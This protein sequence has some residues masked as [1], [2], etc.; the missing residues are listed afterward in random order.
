MKYNIK[1]FKPNEIRE[2]LYC[3]EIKVH[4]ISGFRDFMGYRNLFDN[5]LHYYP[6]FTIWESMFFD[7]VIDEI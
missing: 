3:I 1:L 6:R 4:S 7:E 2:H 5:S